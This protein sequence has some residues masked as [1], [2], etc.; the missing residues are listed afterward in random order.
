MKKGS[1]GNR[2]ALF[3]GLMIDDA[4]R[5]SHR[6]D[7][8]TGMSESISATETGVESLKATAEAKA[9]AKQLDLEAAQLAFNLLF[10]E[11]LY[12]EAVTNEPAGEA[13]MAKLRQGAFGLDVYCIRCKRETTFRTSVKDI[14]A[15]G[16][17]SRYSAAIPPELFGIHAVCQRDFTVYSYVMHVI[18][19][20]VIKIGQWPSMADLAFG[21]LKTIDKSLDAVDRGELGRALGL[22]SHDA[23]IGAFAYLRRVFE[24]MIDRA[25]DRQASKDNRVIGFATMRMDEKVRALKNELPDMVVRNSGVFSVLSLGLHELSEEQCKKHFPVIKAVLFQMLEQE[26]HRR[27][28]AA[29]QRETEAALQRILSGPSSPGVLTNGGTL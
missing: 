24:R 26:E 13:L 4:F 6:I 17:G 15:R 2:R 23:A 8:E 20:K 28:A 14:P 27:K 10:V 12:A 21:E 1:P 7:T 5:H 3:F 9:K 11:G 19:E 25:H 22:F 18:E 16:V 29:T